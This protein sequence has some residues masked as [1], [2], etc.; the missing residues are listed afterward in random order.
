MHCNQC[1]QYAQ[2]ATPEAEPLRA[3]GAA[4]QGVMYHSA[5]AEVPSA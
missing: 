5:Q 3:L 2:Q 1:E 4:D